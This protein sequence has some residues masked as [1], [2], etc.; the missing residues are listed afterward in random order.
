M[1]TNAANSTKPGPA[2]PKEIAVLEELVEVAE[3]VELD[4]GI[5]TSTDELP[6][7]EEY[8]ALPE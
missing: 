8:A 5:T 4:T 1:P 7:L 2:D 3:V 6:A